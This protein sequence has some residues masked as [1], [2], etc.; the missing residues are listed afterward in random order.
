ML[1][2]LD[3]EPEA[4]E[5]RGAHGMSLLFHAVVGGDEALCRELLERGAKPSTVAEGASQDPLHATVF[6]NEVSLARLLLAHG[7]NPDAPNY[8]GR[9]PRELAVEFERVELLEVL[10]GA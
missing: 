10:D 4:I 8:Q 2:H 9:T 1:E 6:R 7:A 5:S 3:R